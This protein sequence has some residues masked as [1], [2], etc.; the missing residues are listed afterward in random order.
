MTEFE[1]S[2]LPSTVTVQEAMGVIDSSAGKIALV[3]DPERRLLG[4]ITD[5]D[6]RRGILAGV[7]LE[8]NVLGVM[9]AKPRT[10]RVGGDQVHLLNL[11]RREQV[12]HLPLLD[13][14]GTVVGLHTLAE[15]LTIEARSN[16]VVLMAG[17]EGQR[18]RPI[19][20]DLPKPMIR[21]GPKPIL[22]TIID[23]FTSAGFQKFFLCVNYKSHVIE[24]HF[25]DGSKHG[26]EIQYIRE[27]KP[28]GTAGPLSLLPGKPDAPLIVMNGDILT[29]VDFAALFDFHAEQHAKGT[30]CVREYRAQVP[31]GVVDADDSRLNGIEEKPWH[32]HFVNAGIYVLEPDA[33]DLVP[34]DTTFTMPNLFE[35][36]LDKNQPCAVFPIKEY[37]LDIGRHDDLE[38]AKLDFTEFFE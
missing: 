10:A 23:R 11:M 37:W 34:A 4:T 13:E 7:R 9:N 16:W 30:M 20:E 1:K 19:T 14:R 32:T 5:G 22:E 27:T 2:L 35:A 21:V 6:I 29:D 36:L 25:G 24:Q 17:G 15:L 33:L 8:D 38:R 26:I 18:L 31:Y 28:L 3:I 12:R